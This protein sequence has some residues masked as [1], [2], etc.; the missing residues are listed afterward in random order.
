MI[1]LI[2]GAPRCG[3]TITARR[4]QRTLGCSYV[5]SDYLGAAISRYI[6]DDQREARFP[7]VGSGTRNDERFRRFSSAQMLAGYQTRARTA[8]PGLQ[9][10]IEYAL[11]EGQEYIVEG[12]HIEPAFARHLSDT[13]GNHN[14]RVGFLIKTDLEAIATGLQEA[15]E[16]NDWARG[17]TDDP[18][19]FRLIAA[20]VQRYS[21]HIRAEADRYH[22]PTFP[23][24][25]GFEADIAAALHYFTAAP[26]ASDER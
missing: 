22:F 1:Y 15:R 17:R 10:F 5:P 26:S 12:F 9:A 20:W 14:L 8:R 11:H 25:R 2:G 19:T 16:V 21:E 3:K 24:D 4:L 13:Y 6:P 7:A 23:T 18:A